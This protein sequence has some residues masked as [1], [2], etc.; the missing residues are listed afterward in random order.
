V[1]RSSRR[2]RCLPTGGQQRLRPHSFTNKTWD[3]SH[4]MADFR[5]VF[6]M[7]ADVHLAPMKASPW[8]MDGFS[9]LCQCVSSQRVVCSTSARMG[10]G[11]FSICIRSRFR[12]RSTTCERRWRRPPLVAAPPID[13]PASVSFQHWQTRRR[14][15][16][17]PSDAPVKQ[18]G[19]AGRPITSGGGELFLPCLKAAHDDEH[20]VIGQAVCHG[21]RLIRT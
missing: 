18:L 15:V 12:C 19:V 10:R 17:T 9:K 13:W 6:S 2:V 1:G 3:R 7:N 8:R 21:H 14:A 5:R 20:F 11:P 4:P 16:L